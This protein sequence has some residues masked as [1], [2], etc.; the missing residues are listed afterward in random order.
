MVDQSMP[1]YEP[2]WPPGSVRPDFERGLWAYALG[3]PAWE[4][5]EYELACEMATEWTKSE[6]GYN[7]DMR[8]WI[9]CWN[10]VV[11]TLEGCWFDEDKAYRVVDFFPAALVHVKGR[12]AGQPFV[13]FDWQQ[14]DVTMPVFGWQQDLSDKGIVRRYRWVYCEVP[15]KSGKSAWASGLGLYLLCADGEAGAEVYTAA[16]DRKQAGIIHDLSAKFIRKSPDLSSILKVI[17]SRKTI[18]FAA[19]D[20]KYVALSADVPSSEGL[21][22]HGALIDETHAHP[23]RKLIG[24]LKFGGSARTQPLFVILTTAGIYDPTTIGWEEHEYALRNIAGIGGAEDYTHF[25]YIAAADK[26]DPWD[27]VETIKRANPSF[28]LTI[29]ESDLMDE[30]RRAKKRPLVKNELLRYRL[31]I[32]VQSTSCFVNLDDWLACAYSFTAADM[33]GRKCYIAHDLS[34]N[35]DLTAAIL[36]FPPIP[37]D[38]YYYILPY[39]WLPEDDIVELAHDA[40]A[41]YVEWAEAGYLTLTAGRTV[42]L[43]GVYLM[44]VEASGKYEVLETAY[45]PCFAAGLTKQL[46][47]EGY[48]LF[49]FRQTFE[50]MNSATV[51]LMNLITDHKIRHP[52][53]HVLNWH[54]GNAQAAIDVGGRKKVIKSDRKKRHHVD[55]AIASI[56]AVGRA[57]VG[58]GEIKIEEV[59]RENPL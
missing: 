28:G 11:A 30:V 38:P 24:S 33:A 46:T 35:I 40:Q 6:G 10:D 34:A 18:V 20:S 13:L 39:F 45:D 5:P 23:N 47:D 7:G 29:Q 49:K 9:R 36:C 59:D 53:N 26:D 1:V 3:R 48:K 32:W 27:S 37:D 51:D 4:H 16:V 22:I 57:V 41:P 12:W 55:G 58:E 25:G 2:P 31:D 19:T 17:D 14:Y 8:W 15:K 42:D 52:D 56:M 50:A 21:D 54:I 44:E 43:D